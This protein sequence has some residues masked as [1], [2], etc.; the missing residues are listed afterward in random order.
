MSYINP[1]DNI[2]VWILFLGA[3]VVFFIA[4]ELGFRVGK[5]KHTRLEKGQRPQVATILGASFSLLA[6]FLA[7]TFNMAVS[8]Y[9]ARKVLVL[10]ET[11]AIETT[12]L[13]AKLLPAPYDTEFQD[14]LRKYV[15]VRAQ[16]KEDTEM[17]T[18]RQLIIKSEE[19]HSRLW[20]KAVEL[21]EN[22]KY[23][24]LTSLFI[25]SL[26]DVLDLHGKRITAGLL[27]RIPV[28]IFITLY[29]VA[30]LSM[31]MMG[32]QAGLT[33]KRTPIANFVLILIFSVVLSLISDLERPRQEIFSVSQ[34]TMVDLKNKLSRIP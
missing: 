13:R 32:Y 19:L 33:G 25:R 27:N 28:S 10:E 16:L 22:S 4:A 34:K 20:A 17:E 1:L 18:V 21:T 26:N 31:A 7:F 2:P 29:F 8:R 15:N 14:L 24:G 23:S 9:D 30:F 3:T 11:N 5:F 6:F 12:Y